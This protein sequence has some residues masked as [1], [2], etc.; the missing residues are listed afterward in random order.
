LKVKSYG[1]DAWFYEELKKNGS[2]VFLLGEK[3]VRDDVA[4]QAGSTC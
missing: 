4:R 1:F 2:P 3:D